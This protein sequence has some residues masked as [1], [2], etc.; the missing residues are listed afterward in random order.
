[1]DLYKIKLKPKTSYITAWKANQL[2]GAICWAIQYLEGP[3]VL[4]NFLQHY[5]KGSPPVVLSN[6]FHGDYLPRPVLPPPKMKERL[7]KAESMEAMAGHKRNKAIS[8]L[9][10]EEFNTFLNGREI[11]FRD[12]IRPTETKVISYHNQINRAT[13]TAAEEGGLYTM[14]EIYNPLPISVY[15]YV[16]DGYVEKLTIWLQ[17]AGE[18]G[19]GKRKSI[20]KGAF[21][22][23]NISPFTGFQQPAKPNAFVALADFVPKADDPVQGFYRLSTIYGRLAGEFAAAENPFKTPV[24]SITAG[25]IF[26]TSGSP[27]PFYGRAVTGVA[28]GQPAVIHY[29]FTPAV[30]ALLKEVAG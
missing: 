26:F 24:V 2:F 8:W 10:L 19:I 7:P 15:A 3:S 23:E 12:G 29:G 5:I 9:T 11:I 14:E 25:S 21:I 13:C 1:M 6:G 27:R 30:P 4:D 18:I 16:E 28:K 22:V 17:V 20:G